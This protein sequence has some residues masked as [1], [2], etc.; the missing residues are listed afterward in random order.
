MRKTKKSP[1]VIFIVC[2]LIAITAAVSYFAIFF[3]KTTIFCNSKAA[4]SA[5]TRMNLTDADITDIQYHIL[6]GDIGAY[7][8]VLVF[9]QNE[10]AA[11]G[12]YFDIGDTVFSDPGLEHIPPGHIDTLRDVGIELH[13]IQNHGGTWNELA[14]GVQTAP[15]EIHW[16]QIDN[17]YDGE[18]NIVLLSSIPRKVSIDKEK[19]ME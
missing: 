19:I 10:E 3:N 15:F 7:T 1:L 17:T 18:S 2:L 8:N 13:Q 12:H 14:V 16:Y 4:L 6:N 5:L 11:D 9:L